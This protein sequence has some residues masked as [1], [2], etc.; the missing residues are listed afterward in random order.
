MQRH[1]FCITR[2][3]LPSTSQYTPAFLGAF[4]KLRRETICF[5]MLV[6]PHGTTRFSVDGFSWNFTLEDFSKI[7]WENSRFIKIR[8]VQR[9]LHMKTNTYFL[10][11]LAQFFL[12]WEML[13]TK[14]VQTI[15]T[16]ISCSVHFFFSKIVPFM[17]QCGKKY[18]SRAG[19]AT[20]INMA[21]AHCML[22][23]ATD[24]HSQYVV[25]IAFPHQQWLHE[26]T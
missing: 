12:E 19:Q 22:D 2:F 4:P 15:K 7:Y 9:I 14:A 1:L 21:Q 24:T 13:Q 6:R 10:P 5:V 17:R 23:K 18:C 20:D 3:C 11:Y 16:Y 25:L 26:R 8:Q